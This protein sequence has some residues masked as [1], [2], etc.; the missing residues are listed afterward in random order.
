MKANSLTDSKPKHVGVKNIQEQI[1]YLR[2]YGTEFEY[3]IS[4]STHSINSKIFNEK[5]TTNKLDYN[6][7]QF[8]MRVQRNILKSEAALDMSTIM[9]RAS[10]VKYMDVQKH[11]TNN[12]ITGLHEIDL[13]R[14]YWDTAYLLKYI[15]KNIYEEG[16]LV[17][18]TVRLMALGTMAKKT[19]YFTHESSKVIIEPNPYQYIWFSICKRV[20]DVMLQAQKIVGN[21]MILFWVDSIIYKQNTKHTAAIKKLFSK[22]G[23]EFKDLVIN[24]AEYTDNGYVEV[25]DEKHK[26]NRKFVWSSDKSHILEKIID[27]EEIKRLG[28]K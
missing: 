20:S 8:I 23:Y 11:P 10:H 9:H 13:N 14:A 24:W 19:Y 28:Y 6:D 4:G 16:C 15:D 26:Y 12:R 1:K 2:H 25:C 7:L 27:L 17:N 5:Y 22:Y 18:K 3:K 21:D